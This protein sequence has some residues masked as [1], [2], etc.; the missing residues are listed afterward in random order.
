MANIWTGARLGSALERA[1]LDRGGRYAV[2]DTFPPEAAKHLTNVLS[3]S[4]PPRRY[5]RPRCDWAG[6]RGH[7]L[8]L[9]EGCPSIGSNSPCSTPG[10]QRRNAD[11]AP[12]LVAVHA[13][14]KVKR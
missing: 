8:R 10:S 5:P 13:D 9:H 11:A 7:G 14:A 2:I 12:R 3:K 1:L 6:M 4:D